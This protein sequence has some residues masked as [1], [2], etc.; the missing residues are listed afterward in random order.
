MFVFCLFPLLQLFLIQFVLITTNIRNLF[1]KKK[2]C[3]VFNVIIY[4]A[5]F[6]R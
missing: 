5:D 1:Y 4:S 3:I 6:Q 2:Y